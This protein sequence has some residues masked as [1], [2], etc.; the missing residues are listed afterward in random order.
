MSNIL[1]Q[2]DAYCIINKEGSFIF[3]NEFFL[4]L[5]N[6]SEQECYNGLTIF[7]FI[8]FPKLIDIYSGQYKEI[9]VKSSQEYYF[10]AFLSTK[11][12]PGTGLFAISIRLLQ[13][14]VAIKRIVTSFRR[15][16][17]NQVA[18]ICFK[19]D[20]DHFLPLINYNT[21]IIDDNPSFV[22]EIG[23]EVTNLVKNDVRDVKNFSGLIKPQ[24][25]NKHQNY[26]FISYLFHLLVPEMQNDSDIITETYTV[27]F[28]FPSPLLEFFSD[29]DNLKKTISEHLSQLHSPTELS[30]QFLEEIKQK[31]IL[32]FDSQSITPMSVI[33]EKCHNLEIFCQNLVSLS[34]PEALNYFSTFCIKNFDL[35]RMSIY[36]FTENGVERQI[37]LNSVH[38]I[39]QHFVDIHEVE[40][41]IFAEKYSNEPFEIEGYT[42]Y[43][44]FDKTKEI[45]GFIEC[46]KLDD[47]T[48]S[49]ND[50][51]KGISRK[52]SNLFDLL[53]QT[54]LENLKT[55]T[56]RLLLDNNIHEIFETARNFIIKLFKDDIKV[57]AA[58]VYDSE[59][60]TLNFISQSGYAPN[61]DVKSIGLNSNNSVCAK[62]GREKVIIN[63]PD[64]SKCNFYLEGDPLVRSELAIPLLFNNQLIGVM[65]IESTKPG[66]FTQTYH[67]P[68]FKL[69]CDIVTTNYVRISVTKKIG[70]M[71]LV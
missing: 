4:T 24:K 58:L 17:D 32:Y 18:I 26:H 69:I 13:Q 12:I 65:N 22:I 33:E 50:I 39:D 41:Q 63:I 31:V 25:L 67:I 68:L 36:Q 37:S 35:A 2:Q 48:Q 5:F 60:E 7:D 47:K 52:L 66:V 11:K 16:I 64:V 29:E 30:I 19:L 43:P 14:S 44:Y 8:V 55:M 10:A 53:V 71:N 70:K 20:S 15:Y 49:I 62:S 45:M 28:I 59:T 61:F 40:N 57:F 6:V 21:D 9:V 23:N 34:Y 42:F 46:K 27:S 1:S 3:V 51:I 56:E 38:Q 54:N